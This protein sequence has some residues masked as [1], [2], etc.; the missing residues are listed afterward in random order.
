MWFFAIFANFPVN[1]RSLSRPAELRFA[2]TVCDKNA[3]LI[4]SSFT[5]NIRFIN[6]IGAT[7]AIALN[8]SGVSKRRLLTS[9]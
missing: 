2:Y 6:I 1:F 8:E 5:G 7:P 9:T 4:E 3:Q